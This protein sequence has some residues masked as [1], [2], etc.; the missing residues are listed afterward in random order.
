MLYE[1][2]HGH[3][4]FFTVGRMTEVR[5][6]GMGSQ[7]RVIATMSCAARP[8]YPLPSPLAPIAPRLA[9]CRVGSGCWP[10]AFPRWFTSTLPSFPA[11]REGYHRQQEGN[12]A[13][14]LLQPTFLPLQWNRTL[15]SAVL[16]QAMQPEKEHTRTAASGVLVSPIT[17]LPS[18]T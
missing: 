5:H 14:R 16:V 13:D 10:P 3:V 15:S 6:S 11:A 4:F 9:S 7:R 1:T 18:P 8:C 12:L 2:R 17:F